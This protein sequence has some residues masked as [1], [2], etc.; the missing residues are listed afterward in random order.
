[1]FLGT[2]CYNAGSR[3][4]RVIKLALGNRYFH[5][6]L[7]M[8]SPYWKGTGFHEPTAERRRAR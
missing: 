1:M 7:F 8:V 4:S 2:P 3:S 5:T 6:M